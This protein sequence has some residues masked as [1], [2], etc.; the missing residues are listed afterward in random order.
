MGVFHQSIDSIYQHAK[1]I[2]ED[3]RFSMI[4]IIYANRVA[5]SLLILALAGLLIALAFAVVTHGTGLELIDASVARY[6]SLS[7]GVCT[8]V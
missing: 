8:G 2:E 7:G 3:R 6:C 4:A 5:F 1:Y